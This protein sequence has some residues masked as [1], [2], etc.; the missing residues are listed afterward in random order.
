MIIYKITNRINGKVY[1]GQTQTSLAARWRG[2][3]SQVN[4]KHSCFK[5][6]KAI[7]ECG[8]E[9]FTVEQIDIAT[10]K[11]EANEKEI[12]WIGF[13]NATEN[14]YNTSRGGK[15]SGRDKKV[16]NVE[17]GEVFASMVEAAK[18]VGVTTEALRQA[19]K[20]PTWKCRGCHWKL[21]GK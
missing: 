3:R 9:N 16:M 6:H 7:A 5:L 15:N 14:G 8:A 17:T 4:K 21:V 12:Y 19:V 20:N 10:T 11:E 2:H 18:A 13:Y 1:I